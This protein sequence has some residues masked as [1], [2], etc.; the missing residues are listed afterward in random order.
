MLSTTRPYAHRKYTI[1]PASAYSAWIEIGRIPSSFLSL[2]LS[3]MSETQI[4]FPKIL[5][6]VFL[7]ILFSLKRL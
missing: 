4:N 6:A 2:G 3:L 5:D 7:E 1:S